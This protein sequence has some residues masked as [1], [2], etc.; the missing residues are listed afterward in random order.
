[1]AIEIN[2]GDNFSNLDLFPSEPTGQTED[3]ITGKM[4][5][6]YFQEVNF[7]G[8]K[9]EALEIMKKRILK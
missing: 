2:A 3:L 4:F 5:N 1:M 9:K 7:H 6:Q 8:S